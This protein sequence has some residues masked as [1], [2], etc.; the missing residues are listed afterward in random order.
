M[1]SERFSR[2]HGRRALSVFFTAGYPRRDDTLPLLHALQA[3]G[4]DMVEVGFPFS[5]PVADGPTIQESNIAA[6]ANGMVIER[7]FQQLATLRTSGVTI[8]VML[9]GYLNPVERYGAERFFEQ[10]SACGVDGLILP[11]MPFDEYSV[12]YKALFTRYHLKPAFLVTSRTPPERVRLLDDEA[13]AFLYVLSSDAVTGGRAT[14]T[15]EREAY[16]KRLQ[17]MK[18]SSPLI[19]G[20]GV[21]DRESFNAVTEHT[22]GAIIGSAFVRAITNLPSGSS[23]TTSDAATLSATVQTFINHVR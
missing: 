13:P 10:A 6:I 2:L 14:V 1:T 15:H 17:D 21:S 8:P 20:F 3:T 12:R 16:F 9:M 22:N 18:L 23:Q 19:V 11:D 4:V 7:L 5:D